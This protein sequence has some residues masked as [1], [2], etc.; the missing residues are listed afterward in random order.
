MNIKLINQRIKDYK[1]NRKY[2]TKSNLIAILSN[3]WC[4]SENY[5][6]R[7]IGMYCQGI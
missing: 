6:I 4:E 5:T 2:F 3:L 7:F 1:E